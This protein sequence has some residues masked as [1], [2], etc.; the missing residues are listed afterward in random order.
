[1]PLFNMNVTIMKATVLD[2][3]RILTLGYEWFKEASINGF[4]DICNYTGVWLADMI[5]KHLV[6]IATIEEKLV[7]GIGLRFGYIP[8]NNEVPILVNDFLMTDKQYRKY[9]VAQRLIEAAKDFANKSKMFLL[10]G[11]FSG[12]YP[13]LKDKF[14]STKGFKYAGGNYVY[15]GE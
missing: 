12:T 5:A 13:E 11:H 3:S 9:G 2:H 4:P 15:K 1:M 8:W 10:V 7:G 6:L 14:L